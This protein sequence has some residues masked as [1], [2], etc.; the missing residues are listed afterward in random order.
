VFGR[1][2]GSESS[3]DSLTITKWRTDEMGILAEFRERW[4]MLLGC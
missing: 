4:L 1:C 2:L 3:D